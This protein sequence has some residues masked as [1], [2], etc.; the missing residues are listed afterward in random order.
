MALAMDMDMDVNM[1]MDMNLNK[2]DRQFLYISYQMTLTCFLDIREDL[3][4]DIVMYNP[5]AK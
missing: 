2:S 3:S 5:I 1:N 4:V